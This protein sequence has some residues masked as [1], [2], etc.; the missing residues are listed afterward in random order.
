MWSRNRNILDDFVREAR[1]FYLNSPVPPRTVKADRDKVH[2]NFS[3]LQAS[4]IS[5]LVWMSFD[6]QTEPKRLELRLYLGIP[7]MFC[8]A[9]PFFSNT[10]PALPQRS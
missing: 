8:L 3:D 7:R 10:C 6:R 1:D 4:E 9:L 5:L 2:L